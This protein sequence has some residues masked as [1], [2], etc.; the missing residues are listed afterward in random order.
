LD[1]APYFAVFSL[2]APLVIGVLMAMYPAFRAFGWVVIALCVGVLLASTFLFFAGQ[3]PR[4]FDANGMRIYLSITLM[5]LGIAA[6]VAIAIYFDPL[7]FRIGAAQ[8]APLPIKAGIKLQFFGDYRIPV[9]AD[10]TNVGDWFAYFGPSLS[11]QPLDAA[12]NPME[13]GMA[14]PPH[15]VLFIAFDK[16]VLYRQVV[17]SFSNS[18]IAPITEVRLQTS[19]T[20]VVMTRNPV[21]AG[22]MDIHIEQ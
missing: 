14:V 18:A 21:P 11:I 3:F 2:L 20:I 1:A 7:V 10:A 8:D 12:G 19:R 5:L 6:S 4:I 16:P 15:W 9:Q 22:V 13:G 17:V